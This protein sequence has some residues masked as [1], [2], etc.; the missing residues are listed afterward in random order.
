MGSR[1]VV[2]N[3]REFNTEQWVD[4]VEWEITELTGMGEPA[5]VNFTEQKVAQ[6]GETATT[7]YRASRVVGLVGVIRA[8]DEVRAELAFDEL[9]SL[10]SLEEFP[11]TLRYASGDRTVWVRRDGELAPL[12]RDLPNEFHWSCVL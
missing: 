6:D 4:G 9:R 10:I 11:L 7:S 3:G 2:V 12:S 1:V 8:T 5:V